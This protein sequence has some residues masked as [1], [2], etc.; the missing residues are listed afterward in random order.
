M[1]GANNIGASYVLDYTPTVFFQQL[2]V[3]EPAPTISA[4]GGGSGSNVS[5]KPSFTSGHLAIYPSM[6]HQ[7]DRDTPPQV[8]ASTLA[9]QNLQNA[10]NNIT[11][12]VYATDI[13]PAPPAIIKEPINKTVGVYTGNGERGNITGPPGV[14]KAASSTPPIA[15]KGSPT[16]AG[17]RKGSSRS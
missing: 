1:S 8:Q 5:V 4:G 9:T 14:N 11:K 15:V 6:I 10:A 7:V 17:S 3:S 13:A 16:K 2:Y 12:M